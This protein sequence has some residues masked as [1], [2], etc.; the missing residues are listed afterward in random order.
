M[1]TL[2][3]VFWADAVGAAVYLK[4]RS[5]AAG[6]QGRTPYEMWHGCKLD[7]GHIRIFGII[8]MVHVPTLNRTKWQKKSKKMILVGFR[9]NIKGYRVY[10]PSSH[11]VTYSRDVIIMEKAMESN[12]VV[13]PGQFSDD[14]WLP[15]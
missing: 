10:G 8:I 13:S 7:V 1:L 4:N 11:K 15:E 3:A 14:V 6:L 12:F 9:E 2:M 5:V